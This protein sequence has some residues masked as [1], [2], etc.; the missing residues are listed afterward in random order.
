MQSKYFS[1]D[2]T[3]SNLRTKVVA[4]FGE[5]PELKPASPDTY[6]ERLIESIVSQQLSVKVSDIIFARFTTELGALTPERILLESPEKLRTIGLSH[7]KIGYVKNIA[8]AWNEQ[9]SD[10]SN[11]TVLADEEIIEKLVTVKGIGRWTAEMFLLFTMARP[12]IFSAG[13]FALRKAVI[14]TYGMELATP[15]KEI[16]IFAKR[17]SPYRSLASRVLWK[18]LELK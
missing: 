1:D 9:L 10:Y 6:F 3:F 16:A 4:T 12:D 18:S 15:P 2:Q 8:Q 7:A 11:W 5:L 14:Q 13:D 17:W